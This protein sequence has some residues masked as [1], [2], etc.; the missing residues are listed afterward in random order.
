MTIEHSK[1]NPRKHRDQDYIGLG[2]KF[3]DPPQVKLSLISRPPDSEEIYGARDIAVT[4][5]FQCYAPG[6]ARMRI[7]EDEKSQRVADSTLEAGH[8]TTRMHQHMTMQIIGATRSVTHDWFHAHPFYNS[9]Q[10]SQRYVEAK[11]GNYLVPNDLSTSQREKYLNAASYANNA[12]FEILEPLREEADRRIRKMYP[13]KGWRVES[14]ADRLESKG[15]KVAQEVA[16]YVLPIGQKTTFYHTLSELQLI[17]LF[18]SSGFSNVSDEGRF[19]IG[20]MIQEVAGRDP[21]ILQEL[22]VPL[23]SSQSDTVGQGDNLKVYRK[24]FDEQ[25]NGS[26]SVLRHFP[27]DASE[28]LASTVRNILGRPLASM[29]DEE[30]LGRVLDPSQNPVLS[31]VFET[32]MMDPLTTSLR[33]LNVTFATKLSHT[34]DSQRQR[35]RRTPGATPPIEATYDGTPDY[36]TPL[37][38]RENPGLKQLY[39]AKMEVI[40]SN[41]AEALNIGIPAEYALLLLPN[42]NTL[43]VVESGDLFD[44]LH[45]WKQR[46]CYLAQEEIFFISVEQVEQVGE[47]LPE[48]K[49]ML[50]APCGVRQTAGI[51]PR[52]PEGDRWCGRPVY[53]W[54]LERYKEGRMV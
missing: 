48:A 41:V 25:L 24:E 47:L 28:M 23:S 6:I 44:W 19:I 33:E 16:R 10:Q 1:D 36:I 34:A 54:R 40:Y 32:G 18:R 14:T 37:I 49:D 31:D 13:E 51:R 50:L 22:D 7:R 2:Q 39:D 43:R 20:R 45:R 9:E 35:H 11:E 38:I 17:R 8:H 46:L 3:E 12:Y 26:Q 29:T 42:A 21:S 53:N 30:A 52:C 15:K 27:H 4:T 5:A